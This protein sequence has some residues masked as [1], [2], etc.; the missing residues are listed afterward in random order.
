M[1]YTP[2][3]TKTIDGHYRAIVFEKHGR[4]FFSGNTF[5]SADAAI[6][7]AEMNMERGL[8]LQW[9]SHSMSEE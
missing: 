7:Y 1:M 2:G 8:H 4:V 6:A 5:D 3:C 9:H